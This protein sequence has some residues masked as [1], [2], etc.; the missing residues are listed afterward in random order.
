MKLS[1][2]VTPNDDAS[3][4]MTML[5][6]YHKMYTDNKNIISASRQLGNG[7]NGLIWTISR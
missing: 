4:T 7:A 5:G 1:I 3:R 6:A 2:Q